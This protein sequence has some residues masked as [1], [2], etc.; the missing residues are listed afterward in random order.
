MENLV[1]YSDAFVSFEVDRG[2]PIVVALHYPR[3][4][5]VPDVTLKN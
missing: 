5:K 2:Q 4:K 1:D 3:A